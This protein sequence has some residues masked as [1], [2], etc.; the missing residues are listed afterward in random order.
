MSSPGRI[1]HDKRKRRE[2]FIIDFVKSEEKREG[3]Y[4]GD[5]ECRTPSHINRTTNTKFN[6]INFRRS[7]IIYTL[8]TGTLHSPL[9][10]MIHEP[11]RHT[12]MRADQT[13]AHAQYLIDTTHQKEKKKPKQ[14]KEN[15]YRACAHYILSSTSMLA[16]KCDINIHFVDSLPYSIN[17]DDAVRTADTQQS[18]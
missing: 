2:K 7:I 11:R 17:S 12:V 3:K 1:H 10:T 9:T 8:Y 4:Y 16:A 6:D 14:Q 15:V 18:D 13:G 5:N